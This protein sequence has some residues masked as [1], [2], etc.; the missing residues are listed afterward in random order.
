M[1]QGSTLCS[2]ILSQKMLRGLV[3]IHDLMGLYRG[4]VFKGV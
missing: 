3:E 1:N 2:A 4:I